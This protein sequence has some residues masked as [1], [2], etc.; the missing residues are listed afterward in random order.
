M[1]RN[2]HSKDR[3]FITATEWAVQYGGKKRERMG[4]KQPLPFD[5]C[6]LSLQQFE[7]PVC[8]EDGVIFDV[9][10]IVPFL[11]KH[12]CNP[13]DA[14]PMKFK[15]LIHLHMHKNSAGRWH[16]P[17]TFKV[18]T[19][20][21]KLVAVKPTGQVYSWEAVNELN[22]RAKNWKDLMTDEPFKRA[23]LI[24]LQDPGDEKL[25]ARRDIANFT[26]LK[27]MREEAS[28]E[29]AA[30]PA[31]ANIRSTPAQA[32]L[33]KEIEAN[34]D[35]LRQQELEAEQKRREAEEKELDSVPDLKGIRRLRPTTEDLNP[36]AAQTSGKASNSFTSSGVEVATRAEIRLATVDEIR[37]ARWKV[38]R[39]LGKKGY[40]QLQTTHGNLNLEVHSD[41]VPRTAENFLGLCEKGYYDGLAFHRL[42]P[43]FMV[44]GGDPT[45]TGKGGESLW[46]DP[47]R[48][49]FDSRLTH[50]ARGLLSMANA[51]KNTNRSQFFITF[52][53]CRHLDNKHAIFGRVVG[54]MAVLDRI[55]RVATSKKQKDDRPLSD[56]EIVKASVFENPIHEATTVLEGEIRKRQ[57]DRQIALAKR[58]TPMGQAQALVPEAEK[59]RIAKAKSDERRGWHS[60]P[61]PVAKS[62]GGG[63]GSSIGKYMGKAATGATTLALP[64]SAS[65]SKPEAAETSGSTSA[66][67]F[68]DP[69][70]PA[71][72]LKSS[73]MFS[74][75][76]G[77]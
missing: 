19:D 25:V 28:L 40:V 15:D 47:F 33:F 35:R 16:C 10:H 30:T 69:P 14:K 22:I 77:W 41:F 53:G 4:A 36:G 42:I 23:D 49:E 18:F 31:S 58:T 66:S 24:M 73:S 27:Q 43:G 6:A 67:N 62:G 64:G 13:I 56:I 37:E 5:C 68:E 12:K 3:L 71:K 7:T 39:R 44:Q 75:F 48:D 2:Q 76:S 26:F 9:L 54:G 20:N 51:G 52:A 46:G 65:V 60:Q 8:T 1:G 70:R 74:D 50:N 72:K 29:H 38:C 63:G 61:T 17:V 57:E 21:S 32:A 55:E 11:Q 59:A 34:R 45:A